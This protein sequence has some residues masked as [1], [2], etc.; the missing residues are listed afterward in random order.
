[1]LTAIERET[2]V[3][4]NEQEND[5][6]VYTYNRKLI[7]KLSDRC[8]THPDLYKLVADDGNGGL[9]FRFPKRNLRL[10]FSVP[11]SESR[12]KSAAERLQY[13]RSKI[14]ANSVEKNSVSDV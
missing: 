11:M 7:R 2:V 5:C 1:M 10:N 13:A 14:G 12:K 6:E 9:T 4:F 3:N 8:E